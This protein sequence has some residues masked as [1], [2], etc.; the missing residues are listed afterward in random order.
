[1]IGVV[2]GEGQITLPGRHL[3]VR[4]Y[5]TGPTLGGTVVPPWI[6]V[7]FP[8]TWALWWSLAPLTRR[9]F[10][11]ATAATYVYAWLRVCAREVTLQAFIL[12]HR[13]DQMMRMPLWRWL[14]LAVLFPLLRPIGEIIFS[15]CA[16]YRMLWHALWYTQLRYVTAPKV[17][18]SNP[19]KV[20]TPQ[21]SPMQHSRHPSL[22]S[23]A[24]ARNHSN[25]HLNGHAK[26]ED[27]PLLADDERNGV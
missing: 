20:P 6:I 26:L 21:N 16:T 23:L 25:G 14:Q 1:M 19:S 12:S 4:P 10:L 22:R 17:A 13:R 18:S 24:D 9:V 8:E 15:T 5:R 27:V 7:L 3:W 11:T 2:C